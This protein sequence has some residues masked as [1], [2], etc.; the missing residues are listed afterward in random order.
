MFEFS[1]SHHFGSQKVL[2]LLTLSSNKNHV[3]IQEILEFAG[4]STG[5][6]RLQSIK[7]KRSIVAITCG[8]SF[9]A[10]QDLCNRP[11]CL[12][13][14]KSRRQEIAPPPSLS[15]LLTID[16]PLS[17]RFS[18]FLDFYCYKILKMAACIIIFTNYKKILTT[19]PAKLSLL[20]RIFKQR[21]QSSN[22]KADSCDSFLS[23]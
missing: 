5:L 21:T 3:L 18:L 2:R 17:K 19:A 9:H 11:I 16:H 12:V 10:G 23:N 22:L 6:Y 4:V 14:S 8:A 20:C 13:Q 1:V 7:F 15:F